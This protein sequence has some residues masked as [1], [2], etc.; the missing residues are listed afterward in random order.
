MFP[1]LK[2]LRS[3]FTMVELLIAISVIATISIIAYASTQAITTNKHNTKRIADITAL[4]DAVEAQYLQT[5]TIPDPTA[6]RQYYNQYGGYEH[7]ASGSYGVTSFFSEDILGKNALA[8]HPRDPD[9]DSYYAY[10]K[11]LQYGNEYQIGG[12]IRVDGTPTAYIRG[13]YTRTE[14]D[15]LIKGYNTNLFAKDGDTTTLPYNP[16]KKEVTAFVVESSGSVVITPNKALT[17]PLTAGDTLTVSAGGLALL[18]VSDGTELIVGSTATESKFSLS[19]ME[20]KDDTGLLTK[21]RGLL[22]TGE[23]VAKAPKLRD[24]NGDRSDLEI[25]TGNAVAA[26]RGTIFAVQAPVAATDKPTF[27]LIEGT[28]KMSEVAAV[29]TIVVSGSGVMADTVTVPA[30]ASPI[31][32]TVDTGTATAVEITN[33]E[34]PKVESILDRID[35]ASSVENALISPTEL[36]FATAVG[37]DLASNGSVVLANIDGAESVRVNGTS[38]PISPTG[39]TTTVP[40]DVAPS[41]EYRVEYCKSYFGGEKCSRPFQVKIPNPRS[42]TSV[43]LSGLNPQRDTTASRTKVVAKYLSGSTNV[44]PNS[45]KLPGGSGSVVVALPPDLCNPSLFTYRGCVDFTKGPGS[46]LKLRNHNGSLWDENYERGL[47]AVSSSG[48]VFLP[49]NSKH[50]YLKYDALIYDSYQLEFGVRGVELNRRSEP[51]TRYYLYDGGNTLK[52]YAKY[53][54]LYIYSDHRWEGISLEK[55]GPLPVFQENKNYKVNVAVN[56]SANGANVIVRILEE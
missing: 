48:G 5:K 32:V 51:S 34:D 17:A 26:V 20:L 44:D 9:T 41:G 50:S 12:V 38:Q 25:E 56:N 14:L 31:T 36:S 23:V 39:T 47:Y 3:G 33:P 21:V 40:F 15:S 8:H 54:V 30:G 42:G 22:A 7:S 37:A 43:P 19:A 46:E 11:L 18:K 10:G 6:N 27:T 16:Y 53:G 24:V 4:A 35:S 2:R 55:S 1:S 49:S 13:T 29:T 45:T 28:L 52:V